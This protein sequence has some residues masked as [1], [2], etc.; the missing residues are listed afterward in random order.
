M[1]AWEDRFQPLVDRFAT[2]LDEPIRF[3]ARFVLAALVVPL[4]F[5]FA[6]PLWR[7]TL[8]APQYPRGLAMY[9]YAHQ[10]EGGHD[11][12][13]I[14]EINELNHYIGMRRLTRSE[15][16]DLDWIPFAIG[17]LALL[18]L[19]AAAIGKVR[20]LI[21]LSVVTAYFSLFSFARFVYRLY[22]FGHDLD[23][24]A[25][26]TIAPFMPVVVGT[27]QV[28][29]FTTHSWPDWGSAGMATF[30]IG[31]LAVTAW[32]CRRGY[33]EAWGTGGHDVRHMRPAQPAV[34]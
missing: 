18:T 3:R 8:E 11:G 7:I 25:A 24:R 9:V 29:N 32:H 20:S 1:A 33:V 34:R 17:A 31:V 12:H 21:D 26:V 13:D 22:V 28:A 30:A 2:F 15:F 16:A 5:S 23:S 14:E 10:I 4:V 27:K 19:R 6:A